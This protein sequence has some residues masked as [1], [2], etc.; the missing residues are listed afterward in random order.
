[1]KVNLIMAQD[2]ATLSENRKRFSLK[3]LLDNWFLLVACSLAF[4]T[5]KTAAEQ[6][7]LAFKKHQEESRESFLEHRQ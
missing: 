7:S 5:A 1:M 3:K 2:I 6:L 4:Y